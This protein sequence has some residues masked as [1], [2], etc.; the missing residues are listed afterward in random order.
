LPSASPDT[1]RSDQ[2]SREATYQYKYVGLSFS[3]PEGWFAVPGDELKALAP[4]GARLTG[5]DDPRQIAMISMGGRLLLFGALEKPFQHAKSA[6]RG[7]TVML[8]DVT[9][10][11]SD[12]SPIE[13]LENVSRVLPGVVPNLAVSEV[14]PQRLGGKKFYRLDVTFPVADGAIYMCMLARRHNGYMVVLNLGAANEAD[15]PGLLAIAASHQQ[16]SRVLPALNQSR[17]GELFRQ[18]FAV[19][20]FGGS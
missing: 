2:Q 10:R 15:L 6:A 3:V 9:K 8:L 5:Y 13:Y 4:L 7:L 12:V 20:P 19:R 17:E 16:L 1:V 11:W 14:E 18:Q